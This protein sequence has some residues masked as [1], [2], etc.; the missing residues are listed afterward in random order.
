[1]N[2]LFGVWMAGIAIASSA[3]GAGGSATIVFELPAGMPQ[4]LAI[5]IPKLVAIEDAA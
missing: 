5:P 3:L 4:G 1:M 2:R